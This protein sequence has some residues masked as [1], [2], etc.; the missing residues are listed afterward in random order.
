[1][2]QIHAELAAVWLARVMALS[3]AHLQQAWQQ[4]GLQ[5]LQ[6]L[7]VRLAQSTQGLNQCDLHKNSVKNNNFRRQMV[8]YSY[9][10][11]VTALKGLHYY[12]SPWAQVY[13]AS[14]STIITI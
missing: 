5:N 4:A 8:D 14:Y 12:T 3:V 2:A 6:N 9:F 7:Q 1:M 13:L 11:K 10:H